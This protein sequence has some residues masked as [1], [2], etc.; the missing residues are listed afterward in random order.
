MLAYWS[1]LLW[2]YQSRIWDLISLVCLILCCAG[3]SSI[4]WHGGYLLGCRFGSETYFG[5]LMLWVLDSVF[6]FTELALFCWLAWVLFLLGLPVGHSLES[7]TSIVILH[8]SLA[9]VY[10][11][12][13]VGYW[14]WDGFD[15]IYVILCCCVTYWY[16]PCHEL[17]PCEIW[18]QLLCWLC[19]VLLDCVLPLLAGLD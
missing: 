2:G 19:E 11:A 14:C 16:K 15:E 5:V 18:V 4:F 8:F 7:E 13:I 6:T 10:C 1:G 17:C 9:L 12:G 3:S